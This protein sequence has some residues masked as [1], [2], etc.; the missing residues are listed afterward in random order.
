MD[1]EISEIWFYRH[2]VPDVQA[3]LKERGLPQKAVLLLVNAP[4]HPR[5]SIL[6]S[7]DDLIIIKFCPPSVTANVQPMDQGVIAP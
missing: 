3:F 4:S 5:E 2:F 7:D 6:T 1:R